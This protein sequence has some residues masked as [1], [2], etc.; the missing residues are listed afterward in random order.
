MQT[1]TH[2]NAPVQDANRCAV[3][4]RPGFDDQDWY[5]ALFDYGQAGAGDAG[6]RNGGA[7]ARADD[8]A[9]NELVPRLVRELVLPRVARL[10]AGAW[11]PASRRQTRAAAAVLQDAAAYV[12][13]D[14]PALQVPATLGVTDLL[15]FAFPKYA[16]KVKP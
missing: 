6:D 2:A 1:C 12:P 9:D 14:D 5:Q 10:L 11:N 8:D 3:W 7:S 15:E 13:P 4:A 16:F